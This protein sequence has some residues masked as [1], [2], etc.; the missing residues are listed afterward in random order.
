MKRM[1]W[2]MGILV[3]SSLSYAAVFLDED[4]SILFTMRTYTLAR[5]LT[6]EPE[7]FRREFYNVGAWSLLQ[8]RTYLEPQAYAGPLHEDRCDACFEV[9]QGQI[10]N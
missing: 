6:Q 4:R 9:V 1:I 8:H 3:C 10:E 7:L 5:I 2:V